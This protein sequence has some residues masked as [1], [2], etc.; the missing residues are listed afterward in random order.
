M[1]CQLSLPKFLAII[2]TSL[3][4]LLVETTYQSQPQQNIVQVR[5]GRNDIV[6]YMRYFASLGE[7][8][9]GAGCRDATCT[10]P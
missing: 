7:W 6:D 4:G 3:P 9:G 2:N 8:D 10:C 5:I 1:L